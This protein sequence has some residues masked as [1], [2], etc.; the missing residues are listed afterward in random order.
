MVKSY[1]IFLGFA[2]EEK[3]PTT[4]KHLTLHFSLQNQPVTKDYKT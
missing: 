3:K 1:L 4:S 2:E